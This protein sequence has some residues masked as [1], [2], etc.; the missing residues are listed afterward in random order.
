VRIPPPKKTLIDL[1]VQYV[2]FT[3]VS[4]YQAAAL[5]ERAYDHHQLQVGTTQALVVELSVLR[6]SAVFKE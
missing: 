2:V 6:G 5:A 1:V 3:E 4:V